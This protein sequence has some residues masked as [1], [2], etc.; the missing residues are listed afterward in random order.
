M[1]AA[2]T[3]GIRHIIS[4]FQEVIEEPRQRLGVA[5][6]LFIERTREGD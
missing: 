1:P 4:L 6:C 2:E 3:A 5:F